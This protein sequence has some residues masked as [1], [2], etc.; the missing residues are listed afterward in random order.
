MGQY[1]NA[2][3]YEREGA[4][5]V[6]KQEYE[7]MLFRSRTEARTA[8]AFGSI[9][10]GWEYEPTRWILP[11]GKFRPDFRVTLVWTER[12]GVRNPFEPETVFWWEVK[13]LE[14]REQ[15]VDPRW[16][17]LARRSEMPVLVSFGLGE[18]PAGVPPVRLFGASAG[19]MT[20]INR[21]F[22]HPKMPEAWRDA[23]EWQ[24]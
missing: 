22:T 17:E 23:R 16:R 14:Y 12:D 6:I 10:L 21:L 15:P 3:F 24:F 20:E 5:Q 7:G 19:Q 2:S 4:P 13:P 1:S 9:G 18:Y 11:S 8:V